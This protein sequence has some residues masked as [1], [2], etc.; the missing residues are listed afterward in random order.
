MQT[1]W[2]DLQKSLLGR[3][4]NNNTSAMTALTFIG[5]TLVGMAAGML[6]AP[7]NGKATRSKVSETTRHGI[8]TG[9]LKL[10]EVRDRIRSRWNRSNEQN[11]EQNPEITQES[12]RGA[13]GSTQSPAAM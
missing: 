11:Q 7:D 1:Y 9:R 8:D 6:M 4:R 2:L 12:K 3:R 5:G 10:M 13:K